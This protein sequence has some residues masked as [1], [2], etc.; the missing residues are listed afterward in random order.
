MFCAGTW[1]FARELTLVFIQHGYC[2]TMVVVVVHEMSKRALEEACD[3]WTKR[4][5]TFSEDVGRMMQLYHDGHIQP[6]VLDTVHHTVL[7]TI[8]HVN[9]MLYSQVNGYA[10]I[11]TLPDEVLAHIFSMVYDFTSPLY[12][13]HNRD[14]IPPSERLAFLS[15]SRR[16]YRIVHGLL[17]Q[18][19]P[20]LSVVYAYDIAPFFSNLQWGLRHVCSMG[21]DA[22]FQMLPMSRSHVHIR[23]MKRSRTQTPQDAMSHFGTLMKKL[24]EKTPKEISYTLEMGFKRTYCKS[25]QY[26]NPESIIPLQSFIGG[27][28]GSMLYLRITGYSIVYNAEWYSD[29]PKCSLLKGMRIGLTFDVF[30]YNEAISKECDTLVFDLSDIIV[31]RLY[32]KTYGRDQTHWRDIIRNDIVS[33]SARGIVFK[34]LDSVIVN[35]CDDEPLDADLSRFLRET[36]CC[37][38]RC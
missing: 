19:T 6:D 27:R 37:N 29:L 18:S 36:F 7:T 1:Q 14:K 23:V 26:L 11:D 8:D 5:K 24:E 9:G 21:T 17:R 2:C 16:W 20:I 22:G 33:L 28:P 30:V 31:D 32:I 35:I 38:V 10:L 3:R 34:V 12:L 4:Q 13:V 25:D 15:V